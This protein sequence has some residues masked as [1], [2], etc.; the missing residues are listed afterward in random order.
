MRERVHPARERAERPDPRPREEP[1]K[2]ADSEVRDAKEPPEQPG[3][4]NQALR[5]PEGGSAG[6]DLIPPTPE[7]REQVAVQEE[8]DA[9]DEEEERDPEEADEV[10]RPRPRDVHRREGGR[11]GPRRSGRRGG[12]RRFGA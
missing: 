8:D 5:R 12:P 9:Q 10:G 1:S 6:Q 7:L 11:A 3:A 4:H 2:E